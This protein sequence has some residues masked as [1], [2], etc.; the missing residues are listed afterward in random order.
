MSPAD[1]FLS[2]TIEDTVDDE[3]WKEDLWD[4][5]EGELKQQVQQCLAHNHRVMEVHKK[6]KKSKG[7]DMEEEIRKCHRY[8]QS[9]AGRVPDRTG[10]VTVNQ[11]P[12]HSNVFH[13]L[14]AQH[15]YHSLPSNRIYTGRMAVEAMQADTDGAEV[16]KHNHHLY[17]VARQ[18]F[19][20][21]PQEVYDLIALVNDRQAAPI[22]WAEGFLLI[23]EL[24]RIA[25]LSMDQ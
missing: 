4:A 23:M 5:I 8:N 17:K 3:S 18:G 14:L 12:E 15:F 24:H 19:P 20:M 22:D 10:V 2:D 6:K 13:G 25:T 16:D 1:V 21:N 9:Q 11:L 7:R